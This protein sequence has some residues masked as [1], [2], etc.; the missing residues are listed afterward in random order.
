M[1]DEWSKYKQILDSEDE[2][3]RRAM[4]K[5]V[6]TLLFPKFLATNTEF[7]L[8]WILSPRVN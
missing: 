3:F 8:G 4:E 6:S 2:E 7:W 1:S 5:E